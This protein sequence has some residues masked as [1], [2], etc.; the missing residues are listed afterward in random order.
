[1][2]GRRGNESGLSESLAGNGRGSTGGAS[3][4]VSAHPGGP[5]GWET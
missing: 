4:A 5:D 3:A 1:M 2:I